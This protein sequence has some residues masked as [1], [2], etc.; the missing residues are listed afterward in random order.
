MQDK[1]FY[2]TTPIY[3]VNDVPHIGHA[4]TGIICDVMSRFLKFYDQDVKFVTGTDEHGQKV[5][6]AAEKMMISPQELADKTSESFRQLG[7]VMNF[8]N[9]DFIRTTEKRHKNAVTALWSLLYEKGEIYLGSYSGWYSVRDEAFYQEKD[10]IDGIAPTG[11]PVEWVEEPSY[12]FRLSKW[13]EKLLELYEN[14]PNFIFPSHR[15]NEVISFVKSGLTDLS[16]SR[17]SFSW[18]IKVP[19]NSSHVIYVWID[20]LTYYLTLLGFPDTQNHEYKKFWENGFSTH[21]IGK[22]ILRFHAVYWPAILLAAELPL[23]KQIA[24]HGWWLNEGQKMS[25]SIGNTINP[26]SLTA[27]FSADQI[28]YF[29]LKEVSFGK[30]GN[31]CKA[32]MIKCINSDLAN[33]IG[34][35]IQ[36]TV[37]F[38]HRE[39]RGFI[40]EVDYNLFV[41]SEELP[42]YEEILK[43]IRDHLFKYE[44]N[45]ILS[46]I[47]DIASKANSYID[48]SAP[49]KL[50]KTNLQLTN[51]VIYK[52]LEYIRIIGILL[53]PIIPSSANAILDQLQIPNKKRDVKHFTSKIQSGI[54]LPIAK[55]IFPKFEN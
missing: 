45:S 16:I 22:D 4:Y 28:R 36:R 32:A 37:S 47:L 43:Q 46:I 26:I 19:N 6:K 23:P 33:N 13:Q 20:A 54:L 5:E 11:S 25:K 14:Q 15:C 2:I 41:E 40:P 42:N 10:L 7:Q 44:F 38:V 12:F 3:Y 17:T 9:D 21:V 48:Q 53:Q 34:N 29:L 52:L 49:W 27:E 35:L 18:G 51:V 8:Q 39:Y 1:N 31:F 50:K 30:D 55:P 24:V